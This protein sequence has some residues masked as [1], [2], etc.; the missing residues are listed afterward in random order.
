MS[1]HYD[2]I[3][4]SDVGDEE[5]DVGAAR[6]PQ[7]DELQ[8]QHYHA[9]ESLGTDRPE[10]STGGFFQSGTSTQ[11]ALA[12]KKYLWSIEYYAQFFN[13][14]SDSVTDRLINAV[15]VYAKV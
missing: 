5:G 8:F 2:Q 7:R 14:N 15:S 6:S 12:S 13:V 10:T 11:N 4:D 1:R 3:I 9:N